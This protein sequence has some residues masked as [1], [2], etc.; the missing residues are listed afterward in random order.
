MGKADTTVGLFGK[1]DPETPGGRASRL[2]VFKLEGSQKD[3]GGPTAVDLKEVAVWVEP[4]VVMSPS[5]KWSH[6]ACF[7]V[8]CKS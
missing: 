8:L 3:G 2:N 7:C 5:D 1:L 4:A 6:A